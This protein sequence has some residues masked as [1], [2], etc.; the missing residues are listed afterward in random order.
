MAGDK[1]VREYTREDAKMFV[2]HLEMKVNKKA[3]IRRRINSLSAI[4]NYAYAEL[5]LDKRN[6]FS[7]LIIKADG[8]DSH[9]RGTLTNDQLKE[10]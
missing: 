6:P 7:R 2:R 4:L 9:K 5:D 3:S 1:D 10:G 8:A